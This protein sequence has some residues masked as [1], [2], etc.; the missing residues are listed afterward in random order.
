MSLPESIDLQYSLNPQIKA[1][2][3]KSRKIIFTSPEELKGRTV[4]NIFEASFVIR[5]APS[6]PYSDWITLGT[7]E[8]VKAWPV[9]KYESE[10]A[11]YSKQL[12]QDNTI[13]HVIVHQPD[14]DARTHEETDVIDPRELPDSQWNSDV[15]D[16]WISSMNKP[17]LILKTITYFRRYG[18]GLSFEFLCTWV[19]NN[20]SHTIQT[21]QKYSTLQKQPQFSDY[22]RAHWDLKLERERNWEDEVDRFQRDEGFDVTLPEIGNAY[23]IENITIRAKRVMER[24]ER[25]RK[26]KSQPDETENLSD[27]DGSD[28]SSSS[29]PESESS[30]DSPKPS[31]RNVAEATHDKIE[32]LD[33]FEK[34]SVNPVP[35]YQ[36]KRF[37]EKN[38]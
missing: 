34:S 38:N 31:V 9:F 23:A 30:E 33:V 36:V 32:W 26:K 21:W 7:Q 11:K 35:R 5:N 18:P 28:K 19:A 17:Y 1:T 16:H 37:V 4:K 20:K 27:D 15:V 13:S 6:F 3:F 2:Y 29:S 10:V 24:E 22:L 12:K 25:K 14:D 8:L